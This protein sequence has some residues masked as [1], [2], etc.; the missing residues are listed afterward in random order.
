V[1]NNLNVLDHS[2]SDTATTIDA[3][4]D[5]LAGTADN[6]IGRL[7]VGTNSH[8]LKAASGQTTGLQ[9]AAATDTTTVPTPDTTTSSAGSSLS[10]APAD[11]VHGRYNWG[12]SD[13]GFKTWTMDIGVIGGNAVPTSGTLNLARVHLPTA[14]SITNVLL[15][16]FT[17]G[18]GLTAN[19][20]YAALYTSAG[21]KVD[22][23]ADQSTPW[24]STGLKT[25]ALAGGAYSAAAG[26]YYVA[27]W[28]NTG[29]SNPA[30]LRGGTAANVNAGLS[31][32]N[33]RFATAD[34]GLTTAGTIPLSFGTQAA[35]NNGWWAGL[36]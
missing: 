13:H 19:Q 25:M 36:S 34:T 14:Q 26:D 11:H 9:W 8:V 23:T 17:N 4:G 27:W 7:A 29:T 3:K 2:S 12:P 18:T 16:V 32:P 15:Y 30:F 21:A 5:L 28:S 24:A 22:I 6:T 10:A 20:C 35:A 1:A 33:F 31:A